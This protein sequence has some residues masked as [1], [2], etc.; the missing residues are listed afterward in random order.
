MLHKGTWDAPVVKP[1]ARHPRDATQIDYEP[2]DDKE[3]DE[4]DLEQCEPE[5]DLPIN[6]HD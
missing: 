5:L 3:D 1:E 2:Q 4:E 6:A